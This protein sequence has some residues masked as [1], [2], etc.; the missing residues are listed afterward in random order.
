[1]VVT[2]QSKLTET[3]RRRPILSGLPLRS[4]GLP[5]RPGVTPRV[6]TRQRPV[7]VSLRPG[8]PG[9]SLTG[10]LSTRTTPI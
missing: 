8:V 1:M 2:G 10:G 9:R 4:R 6:T 7:F 5:L 3:P